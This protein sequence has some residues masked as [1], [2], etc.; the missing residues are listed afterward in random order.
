MPI[1]EYFCTHC[2]SPFEVLRPMS[3]ADRP[4]ACPRCTGADTRRKISLFAAVSR[5][6]GSS[7]L[8]ASSQGGSGCASCGGGH[9]ATC[10]H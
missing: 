5:E 4:I 8:I 10:G 3:E 2:E 1:Y 7:R 6:G 9:C